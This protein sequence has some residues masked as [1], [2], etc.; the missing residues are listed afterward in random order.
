MHA[1]QATLL[2]VHVR[3][4]LVEAGAPLETIV[5][6]INAKVRTSGGIILADGQ[7]L[8]TPVSPDWTASTHFDEWTSCSIEHIDWNWGEAQR[9]YFGALWALDRPFQYAEDSAQYGQFGISV[10]DPT[11]YLVHDE[12]I[13]AQVD[14]IDEPHGV[15]CPCHHGQV[16]YTSKR[17]LLC[18]GCG[19]L[20]CILAEPIGI[21]FG[22]GITS[23]RWDAAFDD[24]GELIDD[25]LVVP[26]LD[27]RA[28]ERADHIWSTDVWEEVSVV[29]DLYA[30]K[31]AA[32]IA[33][34]ERSFPKAEDLIAAGFEQMPTPPTV[35]HQ[36]AN[37]GVNI[38]L[39]KN[40]GAALKHGALA[41]ALSRTDPDTLRE[42]VLSA[43]QAI[44]L[45]LK[46]RLADTDPS[47]VKANNPTVIKRLLEAGVVISAEEQVMIE[48]LRTARNKLQHH[49]TVLGYRST[50]SLLRSAFTFLDRF[51]ID[52]LDYW[53][54]H[55]C[56]KEGWAALLELPPVQKNA[57][58][59]AHRIVARARS[60]QTVAVA[61][62]DACSRDTVIMFNDVVGHCMYCRWEPP[63]P[64]DDD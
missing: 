34:Y 39:H 57:D 12:T 47:I 23:D 21:D 26:F 28:V 4:E 33:R 2:Y 44:E 52:E 11:P 54:S 15:D 13:L 9:A 1:P 60:H 55:V 42:A 35:A 38:D 20:Y 37:D 51:A 53:I 10:Y 36:L 63:R 7:F 5:E 25:E 3:R 41:F 8:R 19:Q 14:T 61:T 43:F 6:D 16:V 22:E 48:E 58:R 29:I 56:D 18:M 49:G 64:Q 24:H 40:S 17:R 31:D 46:M 59:L 32:E 62:C 30:S 45:V 27:Y 50:R